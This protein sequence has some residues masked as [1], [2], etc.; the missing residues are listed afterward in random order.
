[1]SGLHVCLFGRFRARYEDGNSVDLNAR[2]A[3]ELLCYL[4]LYRDRPHTRDTLATLLWSDSTATRSRKYLRQTLWQLQATI[5]P[6]TPSLHPL[7]L[8][9]NWVR[10]NREAIRWLDVAV[11]E[12]T[13]IRARGV[14]GQQ[15][16][17]QQAQALQEAVALYHGDLLEDWSQD[18]CLFE[19]ERLQNIYLIMLEKLIDYCEF[20]Q[21][22]ETGMAYGTRILQCDR[23]RERT[24]RRLMRLYYLSGNRTAALRQYQRCAKALDEELGV[25][26]AQSTL[27]LYEQIRADRLPAPTQPLARADRLPGTP[28]ST[29]DDLL[30]QIEELQ[31]T[32]D[33]ARRKLREIQAAE[34]T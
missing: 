26:P 29:L 27:A 32:L 25:S 3:Q 20:Q 21:R 33:T 30:H 8:D 19:R 1:M 16:D 14:P 17:P 11:F 2:K 22:Y 12:Q 28:S 23:A 24:H 15:L 7:L 6:R 18:W 34:P 5:R 13:F 31:N 9:D 10:I 4:L